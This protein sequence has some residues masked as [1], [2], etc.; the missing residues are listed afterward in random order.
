MWPRYEENVKI[1]VQNAKLRKSSPLRGD[2]AFLIFNFLFLNFLYLETW[3][4]YKCTQLLNKA[5]S[6]IRSPKAIV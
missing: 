6:N 4:F 3:S 5:Q 1:K 2:S